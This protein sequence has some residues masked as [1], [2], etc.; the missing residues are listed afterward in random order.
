[1]PPCLLLFVPPPPTIH[2]RA[3]Q[4]HPH[5]TLSHSP[6]APRLHGMPG[7]GFYL[8]FS[9]HAANRQHLQHANGDQ[10]P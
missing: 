5:S 8:L 6:H 3:L 10:R 2:R 4:P 9:E 1:M 7:A